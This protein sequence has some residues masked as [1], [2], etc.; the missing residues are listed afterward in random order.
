MQWTK[1]AATKYFIYTTW[2]SCDGAQFLGQSHVLVLSTSRFILL[3]CLYSAETE[4]TTS[5]CYSLYVLPTVDKFQSEIR[6]PNACKSNSNFKTEVRK[7]E[8]SLTSLFLTTKST[9]TI[10]HKQLQD[11]LTHCCQYMTMCRQLE[12]R[13]KGFAVHC[14]ELILVQ[15]KHGTDVIIS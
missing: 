12:H 6:I 5:M 15:M 14:L 3:L 8:L 13:L 4:T 1:T 7:F 2:L 11:I 9:V 10:L